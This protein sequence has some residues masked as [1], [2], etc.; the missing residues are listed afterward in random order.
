MTFSDDSRDEPGKGA[1]DGRTDGGDGPDEAGS[2][3]DLGGL[4]LDAAWRA[5]VENY[6]ERPEL[7]SSA[8]EPAAPEPPSDPRAVAAAGL[9]DRSYLDAHEA[10]EPESRDS[11][12]DE[13][14]FVPPEPPPVP[15][16]TPARR[17]A[18]LGLFGAPLA[19]LVAVVAHLS[20]PTWLSM[21]LVAAFVGGFVFLVAT[22]ERH[23]DDG[24]GGDD[25]AVV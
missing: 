12:G 10:R 25:G 22:M 14:H 1:P 19:M 11:S 7:G 2:A 15:R 21:G 13:G 16:T 8:H 6:G 18:W 9:F 17:L 20:Y 23:T 3:D 4:D 24:W 5:I